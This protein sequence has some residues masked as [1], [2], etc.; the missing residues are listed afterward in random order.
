MTKLQLPI[1]K[2]QRK[3]KGRARRIDEFRDMLHQCEQLLIHTCVYCTNRS[4]GEI[5]D[6]YQEIVCNLWEAWP[7]FEHRC[8]VKTWAYK[9]ALN[10]IQQEKRRSRNKI[11]FEPLDKSLC[12]TLADEATD[13]RYRPLYSLIDKLDDKD[14]KLIFL[15]LD[16]VSLSDIAEIYGT[17]EAAIKQK[18]YRIKQNLKEIK[19][20][21]DE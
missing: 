18:I 12:D 20:H 21:H 9:I 8:D 5:S 7:D 14:R 19:K 17:T 13:L 1:K 10:V 15:Y 11:Y 16:H 3:R 2:Q 4:G 6:L